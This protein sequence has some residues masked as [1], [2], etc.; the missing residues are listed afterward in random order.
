MIPLVETLY[1]PEGQLISAIGNYQGD[2]YE[3]QLELAK[4]SKLG[5]TIP[6]YYNQYME[7]ILK[8]PKL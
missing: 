3:L 7:P 6:D 1:I 4:K 8:G 2:I 5:N